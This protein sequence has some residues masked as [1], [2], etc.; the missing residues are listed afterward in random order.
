VLYPRASNSSYHFYF[1]N[2]VRHPIVGLINHF[3]LRYHSIARI[4]LHR[5]DISGAREV[6]RKIYAHSEPEDL[7]LKV[8]FSS[9]ILGVLI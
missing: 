9:D 8:F 5:R 4:L 7:D 2:L 6:M 3:M 1:L